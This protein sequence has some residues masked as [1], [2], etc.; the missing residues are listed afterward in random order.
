MQGAIS[1][2]PGNATAYSHRDAII[3][4]QLMA[5]WNNPSQQQS[6]QTWVENLYNSTLPY[7]NAD[8]AYVNYIDADQADW[9]NA[10][11]GTNLPRLQQIKAKYDPENF[12]N[13]QQ[14]IPLPASLSTLTNGLLIAG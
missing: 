4:V 7:V 3:I 2:L 11:Y 14:G 5:T 8:A 1:A 13:K 6:A 12:W 10:Y 9:A